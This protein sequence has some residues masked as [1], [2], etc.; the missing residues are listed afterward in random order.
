MSVFFGLRLRET[1]LNKSQRLP[2]RWCHP[3]HWV[4]PVLLV[5][6]RGLVR[7]PA[8]GGDGRAGLPGS[9]PQPPRPGDQHQPREGLPRALPHGP[10]HL[11]ALPRGH[12]LRAHAG[13]A[14]PRPA[15]HARGAHVPGNAPHRRCSGQPATGVQGGQ[16]VQ[17]GR[18]RVSCGCHMPRC[19]CAL[20]AIG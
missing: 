10:P 7:P 20:A 16:A 5:Q 15:A 9:L 14:Q 12:L 11:R 2:A 8:A 18:K 3:P 4:A 13:A 1:R 19:I 17:E 6:I